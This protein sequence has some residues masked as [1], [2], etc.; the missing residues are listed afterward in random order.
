MY[1]TDFYYAD[2]LHL[3]PY[4]IF[5]ND[6]NSTMPKKN[7][8]THS[9]EAF[10]RRNNGAIDFSLKYATEIYLMIFYNTKTSF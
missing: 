2:L 1:Q 7:G 6:P 3:S 10:Y 5:Q 8:A 4:K 9:A